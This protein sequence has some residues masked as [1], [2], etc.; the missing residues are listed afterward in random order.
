VKA[1]EGNKKGKEGKK[2]LFLLLLPFSPFLLP[3]TIIPALLIKG[4]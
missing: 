2:G 1:K 4:R 3:Y